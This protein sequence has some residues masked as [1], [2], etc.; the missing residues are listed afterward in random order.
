MSIFS[1]LTKFIKKKYNQAEFHLCEILSMKYL[2]DS[3][4]KKC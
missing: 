2:I 4:R 1:I 3:K